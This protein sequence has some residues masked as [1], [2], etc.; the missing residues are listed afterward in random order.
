MLFDFAVKGDTLEERVVLA[1]LQTVGSV[2][3]VLG[4]D[5]AGHSGHTALAL[6]GA[7]QDYLHAVAFLSHCDGDFLVDFLR[8]H[9]FAQSDLEPFLVDGFHA[10]G[11]YLEGDPTAVLFRPEALGFQIGAEFALGLVVRVGDVVAH[12]RHL[13]C[14]FANFHLS[15]G[16]FELFP[17][18]TG[19][20][21]TIFFTNGQIRD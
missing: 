1:A 6:F 20:K 12:D 9:G 19:C 15:F 2:L 4:G 11:G 17:H 5:V 21:Y 3:L 7:F 8:S 13:T 18:K 16:L 14:D 10:G